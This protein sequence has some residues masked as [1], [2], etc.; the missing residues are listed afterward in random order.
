MPHHEET[1]HELALNPHVSRLPVA[2]RN[3]LR[4]P[5]RSVM[6]CAAVAISMGLLISMFSVSEGIM[7][8][9]E[10]PLL[11]SREDLVINPDQGR[12]EGS[13]TI[14][15]D[16]T[17]WDEVSFATPALYQ[18]MRVLLPEPDAEPKSR[19]RDR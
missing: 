5:M 9:A 14:A 15:A 7:D 16:I 10:V 12:I 17:S 18:D 11:E 13:H 6:T 3:L 8:S 2:I 1:P 19:Q 4:R